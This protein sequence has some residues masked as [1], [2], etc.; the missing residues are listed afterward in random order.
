MWICLGNWSESHNLTVFLAV[1]FH[2]PPHQ[3][4]SEKNRLVCKALFHFFPSPFLPPALPIL[5]NLCIQCSA[6]GL[7]WWC[8]LCK[9][10]HSLS[11]K[12]PSLA[13][14]VIHTALA[15]VKCYRCWIQKQ[16]YCI[17]S[18][19]TAQVLGWHKAPHVAKLSFSAFFL[20]QNFFLIQH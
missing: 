20:R 14:S 9:L 2:H 15:G 8:L 16:H 5:T 6:Q 7:Q 11:E 4:Q 18:H 12:L 13:V 19:V 3:N 17:S 10:P 1:W